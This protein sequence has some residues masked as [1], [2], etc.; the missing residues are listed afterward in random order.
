MPHIGIRSLTP[1]G[2]RHICTVAGGV[3][4]FRDIP[5]DKT[6]EAFV[7]LKARTIQ[8]LFPI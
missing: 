2:L 7:Y 4:I 3:P 1:V 6:V 5:T 8:A